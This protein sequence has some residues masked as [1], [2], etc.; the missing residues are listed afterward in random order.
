MTN[1]SLSLNFIFI[2]CMPYGNFYYGKTGFLYKKNGAIGS[3]YNPPIATICNQ[4]QNIYNK[5]VPG[6]GVGASSRFASRAK[7]IRSTKYYPPQPFPTC[8][9]EI[10]LFSKYS[11]KSGNYVLNWYI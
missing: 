10:G 2:Y 9:T 4:P 7:L 3:R 6:S 5:Y 8:M 1:G 11:S